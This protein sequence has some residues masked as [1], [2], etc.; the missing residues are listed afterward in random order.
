[1]MNPEGVLLRGSI[2]GGAMTFFDYIAI[3]TLIILVM[4][5]A[6]NGCFAKL[7]R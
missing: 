6:R 4:W 3:G 2:I 7:K 1:M 5:C